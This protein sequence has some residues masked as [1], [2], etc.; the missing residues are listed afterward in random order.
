M[1]SRADFGEIFAQMGNVLQVVFEGVGGFHGWA[2]KG[3]QSRKLGMRGVELIS[4]F[5]EEIGVGAAIEIMR[6]CFGNEPR[7]GNVSLS[8]NSFDLRPSLLFL[9]RNVNVSFHLF[10]LW[11]PK[12]CIEGSMVAHYDPQLSIVIS[13]QMS[14]ILI[15]KKGAGVKLILKRNGAGELWQMSDLCG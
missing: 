4:D 11:G 12:G 2:V 15:L 10:S 3:Q 1:L 13:T 14:L 6:H 5:V 8:A 9:G 7:N